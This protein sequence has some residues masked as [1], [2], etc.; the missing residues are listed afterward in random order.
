M[1]DLN[2]DLEFAGYL[3]CNASERPI[4]QPG[5]GR[6]EQRGVLFGSLAKL[7]QLTFIKRSKL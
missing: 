6:E 4:R 1:L 3:P 7:K 5:R 2:G